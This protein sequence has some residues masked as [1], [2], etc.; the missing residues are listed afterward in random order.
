MFVCVDDVVVAL[1]DVVFRVN[2]AAL[3]DFSVPVQEIIFVCF[4]VKLDYELLSAV[5]V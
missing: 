3:G 5:F 2:V 1:V 4:C